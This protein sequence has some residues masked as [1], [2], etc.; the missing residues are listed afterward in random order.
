MTARVFLASEFVAEPG[1][2]G[3][4]TL[5]SGR[6]V[7]IKVHAPANASCC[8]A[9]RFRREMHVAES[10]AHMNIVPVLRECDVCGEARLFY[11]VMAYVEGET[12]R[13]RLDR[14]GSLLA[15]GAA[16]VLADI[17][18]ALSHAHAAGVVQRDIKP[19]VLLSAGRAL[20]TDFVSPRH[21]R[22]GRH[23]VCPP[24]A[25]GGVQRH[26]DERDHRQV[27]TE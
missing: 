2:D 16:R 4:S 7:A 23:R 26:T 24:P 20:V 11:F 21:H 27:R 19:H 3:N 8:D 14:E 17:A 22:Q 13:E 25:D 5:T 6:R 1:A 10:L 18:S 9:E 15:A 12:L